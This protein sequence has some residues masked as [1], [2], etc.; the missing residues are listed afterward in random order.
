[1]IKLHSDNKQI[2]CSKCQ[3]IAQSTSLLSTH[4]ASQHSTNRKRPLANFKCE[5]CDSCFKT[6]V[7]LTAHHVDQHSGYSSKDISVSSSSS[8]PRKRPAIIT[9]EENF[10]DSQKKSHIKCDEIQRELINRIETLEKIVTKLQIELYQDS[11]VKENDVRNIDDMDIDEELT[12]KDLVIPKSSPDET[13]H[14][15]D[16]LPMNIDDVPMHVPEVSV[17]ILPVDPN[18]IPLL[19]GYRSYYQVKADGACLTNS[20]SLHF[21]ETKIMGR[22]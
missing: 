20:A 17:K 19:R 13:Q 10:E 1:M 4:I 8:P 16:I 3:H 6:K 18:H 11:Q 9:L 15:T 7:Q 22:K 14:V 2:K 5:I 12:T 21:L